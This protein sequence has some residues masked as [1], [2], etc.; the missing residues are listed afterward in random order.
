[1][2]LVVYTSGIS[3]QGGIELNTDFQSVLTG[4]PASSLTSHVLYVLVACLQS[5]CLH[6]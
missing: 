4:P 5:V 6:I 3:L 1:M 2:K